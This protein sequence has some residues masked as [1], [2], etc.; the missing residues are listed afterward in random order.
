M[1]TRRISGSFVPVPQLIDDDFE[2]EVEI[3]E[4]RHVERRGR[5]LMTRVAFVF[6]IALMAG[7][8]AMAGMPSRTTFAFNTPLPNIFAPNA[9]P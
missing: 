1:D 2:D 9:A 8:I 4:L 3:V 6:V 5:G 7:L